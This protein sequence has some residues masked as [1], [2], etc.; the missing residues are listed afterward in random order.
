MIVG[1][2]GQPIFEM[3]SLEVLRLCGS[4][5]FFGDRAHDDTVGAD[6]VQLKGILMLLYKYLTPDLIEILQNGLIRFTPL[7][8]FNDPFEANPVYPN[9]DDE[10]LAALAEREASGPPMTRDERQ[11]WIDDRQMQ[12]FTR[13]EILR[14]AAWTIGALS[15][16]ATSDSVLMWTHYAAVHKG[17]V[18]G[19]DT[20]HKGWSMLPNHLGVKEAPVEVAYSK[21][22]PKWTRVADVNPRNFW[23]TKSAEWVYEN[24]WRITRPLQSATKVE[25][26]NGEEV[27]LFE[28][29]RESVKEVIVGCRAEDTFAFELQHLLSGLAGPPFPNCTLFRAVLDKSEFKLNIA[30]F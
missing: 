1:Q 5:A 8:L 13:S 11:A 23:Y 2:P 25:K 26:K 3:L 14:S 18:I 16:S 24:E 9:I 17:F 15:M 30:P 7:G 22:R 20:A 29:P 12:H 27:H 10:V 6:S 28:Y 21:I 4:G 19:F